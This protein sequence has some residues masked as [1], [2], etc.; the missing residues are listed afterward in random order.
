M[1]QLIVP[2]SNKGLINSIVLQLIVTI[3]NNN[4]SINCYK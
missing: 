4:A 1:L 2:S 3:N